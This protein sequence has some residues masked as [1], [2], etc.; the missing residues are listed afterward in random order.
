[1]DLPRSI[2]TTPLSA[3]ELFD[4]VVLGINSV[5]KT[6]QGRFVPRIIT[7]TA[8]AAAASASLSS[9]SLTA[10]AQKRRVSHKKKEEEEEK[11]VVVVV[12]DIYDI[13]SGN[14]SKVTSRRTARSGSLGEEE[15]RRDGVTTTTAVEPE[16]EAAGSSSP[17]FT[18][19]AKKGDESRART[20]L[21]R[22]KSLL[23]IEPGR[24]IL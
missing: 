2:K 19:N 3:D 9:S 24:L 21:E 8:T 20:F 16:L 4:A 23:E 22:V 6:T 14:G 7:A 13:L 10:V 11:E 15:W 12:K 18:V 5:S 17:M 1:M